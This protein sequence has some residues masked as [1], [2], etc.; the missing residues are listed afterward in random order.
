MNVAATL[1]GENSYTNP[2]ITVLSLSRL[3]SRLCTNL[4][5]LIVSLRGP[6]LYPVVGDTVVIVGV[7]FMT[8]KTFL[9][10]ILVQSGF[11]IVRF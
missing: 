9:L 1:V 6:V 11:L 8:V 10:V 7:G 4:F 3:T 2:G 5:P